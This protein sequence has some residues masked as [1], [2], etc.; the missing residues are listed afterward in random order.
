[1]ILKKSNVESNNLRDNKVI[2]NEIEQ[3]PEK[4]LKP[5]VP[6]AC[7]SLIIK[8]KKGN[9]YHGR[10]MEFTTDLITSSLTY[11]PKDH[12][13]QH[14]A[15]DKSL[16]LK[17][18]AKYPIIAITDP[19]SEENPRG[20]TEGINQA[21]LAFSLNM[22]HNT[23]L[24]D[25]DPKDYSKTV[26]FMNIGEWALANFS[27]IEELKEGLKGNVVFWSESLSML[28]NLKSPFHF[29]IYDKNGGSIVIEISNNNLN[30]YDNPTGV[31]TNGPEFP[32]HL[33]NLNNYSHLSN[34]DASA[35]KIGNLTLIQPDSGIATSALPSSSTSVGRFIRAF[36]YSSFANSVDNPNEQ[37]AELGHIMN[38]FDRPKNITK[39]TSG[40]GEKS[41]NNQYMTEFTVW[42][43]LSDLSR[44][45]FYIRMYGSL[46]YEKFTFDQFKDNTDFVSIPLAK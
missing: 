10:G 45:E 21:G 29:A 16:G 4:D 13:F 20:A 46:N 18:V 11:Y 31:L 36:Y 3:I 33:E 26:P 23:G 41:A 32:W 17:Y 44:A 40:E 24:P 37:I 30:V 1:M 25:P 43:V 8:D 15:P 19:V 39:D 9:V 12:V 38:N 34:I 6:F 28:G 22:I 27:T 5:V 42:T 2:F 35:S 7:T 14:Y